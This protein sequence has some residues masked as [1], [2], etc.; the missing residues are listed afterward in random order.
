MVRKQGAR[1]GFSA[2]GSQFGRQGKP[3]PA[4]TPGRRSRVSVAGSRTSRSN[5]VNRNTPAF[6]E[7]AAT[8]KSI[9]GND[10][11]DN[12]L[13]EV[14]FAAGSDTNAAVNKI[15]DTP[16]ENMVRQQGV[17]RGFSQY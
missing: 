16:E 6:Q 15:L 5:P 2:Y 7:F 12:W 11:D 9:C 8:A 4:P 3:A 14:F 10:L 17:G 1:T 13:A